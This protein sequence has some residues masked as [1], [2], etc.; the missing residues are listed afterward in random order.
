VVSPVVQRRQPVLAWEEEKV[1]VAGADFV[2]LLALAAR[3]HN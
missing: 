1:A 2:V 3:K